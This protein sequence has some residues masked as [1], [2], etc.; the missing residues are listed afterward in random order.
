MII[1]DKIPADLFDGALSTIPPIS[2]W[3]SARVFRRGQDDARRF[4]DKSRR[5]SMVC[6]PNGSA[7]DAI[8][9]YLI[10]DVR[11]RIESKF[12]IPVPNLTDIQLLRYEIGGHFAPHRDR[13]GPFPNSLFTLVGGIVEAESGGEL[14][15]LEPEESSYRIFPAR[16]V[17]FPADTLHASSPVRRGVKIVF[18]AW[19]LEK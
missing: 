18:V 2:E 11:P 8:R 6:F 19:L 13:G 14:R 7:W 1:D 9:E 5:D 4:L 16:L 10:K 15:I 17:I 3:E 12:G